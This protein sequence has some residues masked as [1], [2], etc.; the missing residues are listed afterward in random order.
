MQKNIA[1]T[2]ENI[3]ENETETKLFIKT[4]LS[5]S[6]LSANRLVLKTTKMAVRL[7]HCV[8][9]VAVESCLAGFCVLR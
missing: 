4:F 2:R 7:C 9:V 1:V 8:A 6:S 3:I 5:S